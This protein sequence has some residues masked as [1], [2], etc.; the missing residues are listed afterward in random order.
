[1][2]SGSFWKYVIGMFTIVLI[3]HLMKGGVMFF[4]NSWGDLAT[5]G[6]LAVLVHIA[7]Y[8]SFQMRGWRFLF[9]NYACSIGM[10]FGLVFIALVH[11]CFITTGT[12]IVAFLVPQIV[13]YQW[14]IEKARK[15]GVLPSRR[16]E[17]S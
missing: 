2:D 1:M 8:S 16:G 10:T 12:L 4:D 3:V 6:A 11:A 15:Q 9:I 14:V 7:L 17:R 13:S 5:C